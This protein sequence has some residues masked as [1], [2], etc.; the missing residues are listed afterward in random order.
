MLR[1]Q[2]CLF[3]NFSIHLALPNLMLNSSPLKL[4][5][6]AICRFVHKVIFN[7]KEFRTQDS[8]Y[9]LGTCYAYA[10]GTLREHVVCACA[11][12]STAIVISQGSKVY[13]SPRSATP[14]SLGHVIW[15]MTQIPLDL[16]FCVDFPS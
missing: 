10:Y 4:T 16:G 11:Y 7:E 6:G 13:L 3:K 2:N 1:I 5:V 14:Y 8:E 15:T 12:K 9:V